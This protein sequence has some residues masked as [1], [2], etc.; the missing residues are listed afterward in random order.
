M[1]T[2]NWPETKNIFTHNLLGR[3]CVSAM[4]MDITCKK[5]Y[6]FRQIQD[7]TLAH[8]CSLMQIQDP[9][10][11]SLRVMYELMSDIDAQSLFLFQEDHCA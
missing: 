10:P 5:N 3:L 2:T 11:I 4:C 9:W 1:V 7:I 6:V 8:F